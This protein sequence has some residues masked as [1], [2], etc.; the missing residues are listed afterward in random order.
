MHKRTTYE[1]DTLKNPFNAQE[2]VWDSIIGEERRSKNTWRIIAI[3]SMGA[4]LGSIA[5][6]AWAANLPKTVPLVITVAPW[7][8]SRYIGD[9]SNM[10]YKSMNVPDV[11]IQYQLRDFVTKLRSISTDS[12]VLFQNITD[13][14]DKVTNNG[15]SVMTAKVREEDPFSEVGKKRR[16]V[17]IESI[18]RISSGSWQV[19]WIETSL[20][21]TAIAERY[22]G[23]FTVKL[24]EPS[25]KQRIKNPLG[26][27]I[28]NYDITNLTTGGK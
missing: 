19:D 23:L 12:E 11:A 4:L 6:L 25:D 15:S 17:T 28:D 5:V 16:T 20:G 2:R 3:I 13:C 10:G 8:E 9:V 26:I 7:G 24:L 14:Y 27:Y 22:R 18:L 1:P 21:T